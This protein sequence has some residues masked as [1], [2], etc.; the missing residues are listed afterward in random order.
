MDA[1]ADDEEIFDNAEGQEE[2]K[3]Q[4]EE[5]ERP[6]VWMSKLRQQI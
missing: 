4:Y 1:Y 2:E 5:W 6:W 3:E